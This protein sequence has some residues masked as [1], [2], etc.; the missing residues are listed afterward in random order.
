[1]AGGQ[2]FGVAVVEA[3]HVV[4]RHENHIEGGL[5]LESEFFLGDDVERA[6]LQDCRVVLIV[7]GS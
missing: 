6:D 2:D 5:D 7:D 1:M 3:L 4:I